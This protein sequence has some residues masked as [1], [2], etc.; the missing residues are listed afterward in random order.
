M[1]AIE[2]Q[3]H[4][5]KVV[6]FAKKINMFDQLN[7]RLEYLQDYSDQVTRCKLYKDSAPYSFAFTM[8]KKNGDDWKVWFYGGLIYHGSHDNGGDG[9]A[10]TFSVNINPMDGWAIHTQD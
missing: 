5:D 8:E 7:D 10:P 3:S 9:G 6:D 1:L 2:N 4:F